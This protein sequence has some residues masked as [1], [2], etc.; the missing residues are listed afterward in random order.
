MLRTWCRYEFPDSGV[1]YLLNTFKC[2]RGGLGIGCLW[3][4]RIGVSRYGLVQV[5][6]LPGNPRVSRELRAIAEN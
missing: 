6:Y 1:V 4:G 2:P 5:V 3:L